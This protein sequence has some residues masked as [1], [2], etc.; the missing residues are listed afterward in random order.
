MLTSSDFRVEVSICL[1]KLIIRLKLKPRVY[2][3]IGSLVGLV[4]KNG[5][6]QWAI[7]LQPYKFGPNIC[8]ILGSVYSP[9]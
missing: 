4:Y 6:E 2:F 3:L 5:I 7:Q 9:L 8:I 1:E